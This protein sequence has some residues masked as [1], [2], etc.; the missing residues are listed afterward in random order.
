MI[1]GDGSTN[2][3]RLSYLICQP[4]RRIVKNIRESLWN[5]LNWGDKLSCW[6]EL[7]NWRILQVHTSFNVAEISLSKKQGCAKNRQGKHFL[8][9]SC[10]HILILHKLR[11]RV[12]HPGFLWV[13]NVFGVFWYFLGV[14][15]FFFGIFGFLVFLLFLGLLR[16][17]R[18]FATIK[19]RKNPS[20]T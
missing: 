11:I 16:F 1:E 19:P 8:T 20:F 13:G 12:R 18:V 10:I 14:L 9:F 15:M 7:W 4:W 17:L 6:L 3:F 2:K 5:E